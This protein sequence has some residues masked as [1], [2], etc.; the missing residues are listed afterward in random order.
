[1]RAMKPLQPCLQAISAGVTC[2]LVAACGGGQAQPARGA[3][4]GVAHEAASPVSS[5]NGSAAARPPSRAQALVFARAVNLSAGDIPGTSVEAKHRPAETA[6]ERREERACEMRAGWGHQHTLAE[7]S[8]PKLK[9]GQELEIE[10]ITSTVSV[11]RDES[12]VSR[13]FA[14][15]ASPAAR[16]CAARVLTRNLDDRSIR[17]ARWGHVTVSKLPIDAPE[18]TASVGIRIVAELEIPFNEVSIPI[19]V[20]LLG[21]AIGRAEIGLSAISATQPVPTSTEHE[22]VALL[23]ARARAHPL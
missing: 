12:A 17:D 11:L 20:D 2:L 4:S 16:K 19:Y 23:L 6:G 8:S 3:A 14:L 15:L 10:R 9:R 13:Q 18:T 22:L 5:G 21:F 7:V 1:M